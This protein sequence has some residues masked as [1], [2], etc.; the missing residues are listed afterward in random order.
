MVTSQRNAIS[1]VIECMTT[2][3]S[4]SGISSNHPDSRVHTRSSSLALGIGAN[5]ALFSIFDEIILKPLPVGDPDR[6]V[7]FHSEGTNSGRVSKDNYESVF[8]YPMY[9]DLTAKLTGAGGDAATFDAEVRHSSLRLRWGLSGTV[10]ISGIGEPKSRSGFGDRQFLR[11][12]R[13]AEPAIGRLFNSNDDRVEG[14]NPVLVLS[15]GYWKEHFGGRA[16]IVGQKLLVNDHP[17][18]IIGVTPIGFEGLVSGYRPAPL[19]AAHM[20]PIVESGLGGL[21]DRRTLFIN[22]IRLAQHLRQT[23]A[24]D[25]GLAGRGA[26]VSGVQGVPRAELREMKNPSDKFKR[27]FTGKKLELCSRRPGHQCH[28]QAVSDAACFSYGHGR[29]DPLDRLRERRQSVHRARHRA[30]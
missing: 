14:A 13:L 11:R 23:A 28:A 3:G 18:E 24:R 6:L 9:G 19:S 12:T 20:L 22:A 5:T 2:Y 1:F 4:F 17:M 26:G 15:Y 8:S 30:A 7:V 16:D 25:D 21:N 29:A 27:G 10:S